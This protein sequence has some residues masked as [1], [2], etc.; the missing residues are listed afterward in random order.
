[1]VAKA[2][3]HALLIYLH[4]TGSRWCIA[5]WTSRVA[6]WVV[7]KAG[8]MISESPHDNG[9]EGRNKPQQEQQ[10]RPQQ[11]PVASQN[12][13]SSADEA[14][15]QDNFDFVEA[16]FAFDVNTVLPDQWMQDFLGESFFG[17]L[18][19]GLLGINQM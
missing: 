3:I 19:D 17:Q 1:M 12:Y 14:S 9:D 8:L 6:E 4:E 7:K 15:A 18:D 11:N 10:Y 2:R 5:K 13:H 16:G